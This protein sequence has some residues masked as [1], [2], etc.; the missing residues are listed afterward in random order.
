MG[1]HCRRCRP[2]LLSVKAARPRKRTAVD[3]MMPLAQQYL[4]MQKIQGEEHPKYAFMLASEAG[5]TV[6]RLR[7]IMSVP[8]RTQTPRL[9]LIDIP[10]NGAFYAGPEGKISNSV[11][12]KFVADYE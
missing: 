11:V 6:A 2:S 1:V 5:G 8:L 4:D 3:A 7:E 12:A 9:M 10:D